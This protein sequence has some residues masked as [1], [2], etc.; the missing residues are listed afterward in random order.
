MNNS[1]RAT[2]FFYN[3][4]C[5]KKITQSE[6]REL[7]LSLLERQHPYREELGGNNQERKVNVIMFSM[8]IVSSIEGIYI[9][10]EAGERN[11]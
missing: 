5:Q 9:K 1:C 10:K 6:E 2:I 3:I 7:F 11:R 8:I 4:P